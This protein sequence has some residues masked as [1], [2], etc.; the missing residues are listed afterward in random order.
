MIRSPA[1][2]A[3]ALGVSV[4]AVERVIADRAGPRAADKHDQAMLPASA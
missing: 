4:T 3:R 1:I 2:T